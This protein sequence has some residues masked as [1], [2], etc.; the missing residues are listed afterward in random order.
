MLCMDADKS[1]AKVIG[2]NK[3]ES[4]TLRTDNCIRCPLCETIVLFYKIF[5]GSR[6]NG[7]VTLENGL[8][9]YVVLT[10]RTSVVT[11]NLTV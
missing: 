9:R 7:S 8:A 1:R 3:T 6:Q 11:R 2:T 4:V 5:S 10:N